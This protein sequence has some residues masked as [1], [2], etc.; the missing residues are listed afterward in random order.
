MAESRVALITGS[1]SGVGAAVARRLSA[2]GIRVVIDS[3]RSETPEK[4]WQRSCRGLS[5][6]R[7]A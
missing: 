6:Y 5:T 4:P 2:E 3:A 1:S 7:V